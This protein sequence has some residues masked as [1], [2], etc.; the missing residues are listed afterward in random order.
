MFRRFRAFLRLISNKA[1]PHM[2]LVLR[3]SLCFVAGLVVLAATSNSNFDN[4]FS[5]RGAQKTKSSLVIITI[6]REDIF[7]VSDFAEQSAKNFIRSLKEISDLSDM[8]YWNPSLWNKAIGKLNAAK[9]KTIVLALDVNNE[10]SST[11]GATSKNI[12]WA[13]Q[14]DT[15]N[16]LGADFYPDPD[17]T[18]RHFSPNNSSL[19]FKVA[20]NYLSSS[21]AL[22][23]AGEPINFMGGKGTFPTYTFTELIKGKINPTLLQN[24]IIVVAAHDSFSAKFVTPVGILTKGE[25]LAHVIYNIVH[26]FWVSQI[27]FAFAALYML[28]ILVFTLWV[29]FKFPESVALVFSAFFSL[30]IFVLSSALFDLKAFWLPVE[31]P[32]SLIVFTYVVITGYRLGESEKHS[33][34]SEQELIYLSQV[35]ELK[36]N[37]LSLISHDLKNP[38]AKIQGIT[39]RLLAAKDVSTQNNEMKDD[40]TLIRQTSDEL[41]QYI[42]SILQ[43]TKVEAREIKINKEVCDL[44]NIVLSVL[45]RLQPLADSKKIKI[46]TQLEP[47]FSQELDRS[48]ITEVLINLVEN[49]IKYSDIGGEVTIRTQ[50]IDNEVR[51]EV[52]DNAGGIDETDLTKVFDKFYRG[53]GDKTIKVTGSGLGLYLVKYFIELHDGKVFIE[54]QKGVGTNIGFTLPLEAA[55]EYYEPEFTSAHR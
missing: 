49:A 23:T 33:W 9:A 13:D 22:P 20:K 42:T 21:P 11:L 48:L 10:M 53:K 29:I 17:G 55:K 16:S 51:V 41:R 19:A 40:L 18:V 43:L 27:P 45:E 50:E 25:L 37:F 54:S 2:G 30:G 8:F 12:F 47:L 4:R 3:V 34:K 26:K 7:N 39:D 14:D 36:N 35:E 28:G 32:L 44:N 15:G 38:L 46:T 31:A 1:M 24:K 52:T 5:I 6:S